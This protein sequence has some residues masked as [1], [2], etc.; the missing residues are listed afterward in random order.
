[1]FTQV[2]LLQLQVRLTLGPVLLTVT[3]VFL[4]LQL[5]VLR[6]FMA[7]PIQ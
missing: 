3:D 7:L 6:R 4:R 2:A 1:M 5:L